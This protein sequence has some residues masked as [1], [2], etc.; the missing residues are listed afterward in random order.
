MKYRPKHLGTALLVTM[1]A[2]VLSACTITATGSGTVTITSDNPATTYN[3]TTG[4]V[5]RVCAVSSPTCEES[6]A[7]LYSYYPS[8]GSSEWS[9]SPGFPVVN[10][11]GQQ[12]GLPSG[13]YTLQVTEYR[14]AAVVTNAV[15]IDVFDPASRDLTIWHQSHG[16]H[17]WD[18]ECPSEWQPS[19]AQ[20][21]NQGTGGFVCNRQ[22]Y[23]YYPD[24]PV[25]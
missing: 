13:R 22:V 19:W 7:Y 1:S 25:R 9:V 20:W 2:L 21:P 3:G 17:S 8:G 18:A 14:P 24:E 6:D 4:S 16:R 10:R 23:A 5:A 15:T 12:V 11:S